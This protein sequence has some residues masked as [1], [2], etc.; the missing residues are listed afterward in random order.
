MT[1][2]RCGSAGA[3]SWRN[4]QTVIE[5]AAAPRS[6][7]MHHAHHVLIGSLA[8]TLPALAQRGAAPLARRGAVGCPGR[9]EGGLLP[10]PT[11]GGRIRF[12]PPCAG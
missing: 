4:G 8:E 1:R 5:L 6:H 11:T 2:S 12:S 9:A 10:R 3:T 7:G